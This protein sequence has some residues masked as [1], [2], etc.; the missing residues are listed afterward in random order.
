[1]LYRKRDSLASN[2][3]VSIDPTGKKSRSNCWGGIQ[4]F[5]PCLPQSFSNELI[6]YDRVPTRLEL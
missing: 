6:R 4:N 3:T 1:M 2:A 5:G